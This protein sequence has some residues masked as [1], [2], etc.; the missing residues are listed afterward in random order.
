MKFGIVLPIWQL[1]VAEAETLARRAEE[2]GL[3]GVFV[4]KV[5]SAVDVHR[6]LALLEAVF[7]VARVPA[8]RSNSSQKI[9][10]GIH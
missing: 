1:T 10:S 9:S 8:W 7:L 3:D 2:L 4:P 6:Y 5:E